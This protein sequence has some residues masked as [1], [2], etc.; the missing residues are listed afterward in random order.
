[1]S[2]QRRAVL[3]VDTDGLNPY[4]RCLAFALRD[5]GV[6]IDFHRRRSPQISGYGQPFGPTRSGR[7]SRWSRAILLG[8]SLVRVSFR[9]P[10]SQMVHTLWESRAD[11]LLASFAKLV[12]GR[13]VVATIHDAARPGKRAERTL[14]WLATVADRIIV[15]SKRIEGDLVA[16][17]PSAREKID[18][19]PLLSYSAQVRDGDR[20]GARLRLGLPREA[21]LILFFGQLRAGKGLETLF[22]AADLLLPAETAVHLVVAGCDP[23]GAWAEQLAALDARHP[24]QVVLFV[25]DSPLLERTLSDLILAADVVALPFTRASQSSSAIF[26]L[27]HRRPVVT[28]AVGAVEEL[29][30]AGAV[31]LVTPGDARQLADACLRLI[32]VPDERDQLAEK[33]FAYASTELSPG[34]IAEKTRA[35]YDLVLVVPAG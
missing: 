11:L 3:L 12:C 14:R 6:R 18:V 16:R 25:H 31:T 1:M 34:R 24:G 21:P 17:V 28:T 22:Q 2:N 30:L 33:G 19:V 26:A 10:K 15:H 35:L 27:S 23:A 29:G 13:P 20:G 7:G 8:A 5:E 32:A 4:G 9:I